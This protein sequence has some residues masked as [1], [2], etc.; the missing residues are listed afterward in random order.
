M[1]STIICAITCENWSVKMKQFGDIT[2]IDGHKVPITDVVVGGSPCQSLSI[3]GNR[4]GLDGESGLFYEQIR[5]VKE[6][7]E[8]D[9]KRGSSAGLIRPRYM[10]WENVPGALSSHEGKDFQIVLHEIV[11]I[12][13]KEAPVI[14][15]PSDGWTTSGCISDMGGKWSIA[16][17]ILNAQFWGVPQRRRRIHLVA[18][19]GGMCAP[20]ILFERESCTRYIEQGNE[21]RESY[22]QDIKTCIGADGRESL[23]FRKL[24]H[25]DYTE[26]D[27]AATLCASHDSCIR[28]LIV[29]SKG[30]RPRNKE[31]AQVWKESDVAN[32][33]TVFD[34]GEGRCNELV[35]G[36]LVFENHGTDARYN[37]PL[38]VCP[39]LLARMGTGGCNVP[40]VVEDEE[41]EFYV[42][43]LTEMECERL[44]GLPDGW[45]DIG[46][47]IDSKGK[48]HKSSS[49]GRYKAIGNGIDVPT[50]KWV[51][52]RISATYERDATLASLFDGIGTFPMIWEQING[53]GSCLWSS[54]IEEFPMAVTKERF[55]E[56]VDNEH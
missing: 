23:Q 50:W 49:S 40:I 3:A 48:K 8:E 52:K 12:V 35:I 4:E 33:L 25:S 38:D 46:E 27:I 17:R 42:R 30:A 45:T 56:D 36:K 43:Q 24:T 7:R 26:D 1:E 44:Q 29:F 37:G 20:E 9:E 53:K 2:K 6:M 54:E 16:W 34:I 39:S 10:V 11:K 28:N 19:F 31:E 51:L 47:W 18:D 15:I 5:V 55:K 21:K 13:C 22:E 41:Q 14:S 32:T